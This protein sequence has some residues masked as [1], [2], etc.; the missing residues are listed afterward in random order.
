MTTQRS[1]IFPDMTQEDIALVAKRRAYAS[2]GETG[3][4]LSMD[5]PHERE[6]LIA[7]KTRTVQG[8]YEFLMSTRAKRSFLARLFNR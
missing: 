4:E 8:E 3:H 2:Y 5:I 6:A 1:D 7:I